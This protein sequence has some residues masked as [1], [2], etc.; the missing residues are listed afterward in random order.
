MDAFSPEFAQHWL[1]AQPAAADDRVDVSHDDELSPAQ[2][3]ALEEL[4]E[5]VSAARSVY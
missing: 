4:A 2:Q 5:R 1:A 3:E